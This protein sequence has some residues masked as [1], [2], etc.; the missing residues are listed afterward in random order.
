[1]APVSFTNTIDGQRRRRLFAVESW[2]SNQFVWANDNPQNAFPFNS[3]F[4]P[5]ANASFATASAAENRVVRWG[6][7]PSLAHRDQKINLNYPLPVSNDPNEPVRQKWI[8][9]TYQILQAIFLPRAVDTPEEV[10]QLSQFVINIVDFRDPDCTMT[11]RHNPDV[12]LWND[13]FLLPR[14]SAPRPLVRRT[15]P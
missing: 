6:G 14:R 12:L 10:A 1:M 8:S 5:T 13:G 4:A 11:H 2:E 3:R 7:F 9:D 15:W